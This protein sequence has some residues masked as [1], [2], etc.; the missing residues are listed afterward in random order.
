M[1]GVKYTGD[2]SRVELWQRTVSLRKIIDDKDRVINA[3]RKEL[4]AEKMKRYEL[5]LKLFK[6]E[7]Q[8]EWQ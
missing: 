6:Q 5:S 7:L 3:L 4:E 2:L 8:G 1:A